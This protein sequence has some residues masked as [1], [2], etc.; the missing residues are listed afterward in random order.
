MLDRTN[1]QISYAEF[2]P[3]PT[4]NMDNMGTDLL[5]SKVFIFLCTDSSEAS[6]TVLLQIRTRV[7]LIACLPSLSSVDLKV[8]LSRYSTW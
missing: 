5:V 4:V 8:L 1:V 3:N 7:E 6:I 2:D